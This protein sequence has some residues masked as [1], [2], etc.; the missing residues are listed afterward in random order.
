MSVLVLAFVFSVGAFAL[1]SRGERGSGPHAEVLIYSLAAVLSLLGFY[2]RFYSATL[3]ILPLAWAVVSLGER[4]TRRTAT[5]VAFGI[6]LFLVPATALMN[7]LARNGALGA[8]EGRTWWRMLGF[9]EVFALLVLA[10]AL[11]LECRR[12]GRAAGGA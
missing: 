6:A 1:A 10:A 8:F 9:H 11:A 2:N 7:T 12:Q 4:S 3:L 5:V